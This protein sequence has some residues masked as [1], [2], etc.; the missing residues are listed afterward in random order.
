M[1][2]SLPPVAPSAS[3][4][5]LSFLYDPDEAALNGGVLPLIDD[6]L[7]NA[8]ENVSVT[9]PQISEADRIALLTLLAKELRGAAL[10]YIETS[11]VL[12]DG[13]PI[14]VTLKYVRESSK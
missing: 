10:A 7:E 9:T 11:E 8:P 3:D 6:F 2:P 5:T 12:E 14:P 4:D 1:K 13:V